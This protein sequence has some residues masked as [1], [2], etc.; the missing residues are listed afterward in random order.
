MLMAEA[1]VGCPYPVCIKK[2]SDLASQFQKR[3]AGIC[4]QNLYIVE[5]NRDFRPYSFYQ[6]FFCGKADRQGQI[7]D[8]SLIT[9]GNLAVGEYLF[10]EPI[11]PFLNDS[12]HP[13]NSYY[14][15]ADSVYHMIRKSA[16][17]LLRSAEFGT[18]STA[19]NNDNF[20]L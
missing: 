6:R 15:Y 14:V 17:H 1:E 10:E 11:A 9:I 4:I 3:L 19:Y 2:I 13:C 7:R 8:F 18:R 12:F 5:R 20:C 16:G